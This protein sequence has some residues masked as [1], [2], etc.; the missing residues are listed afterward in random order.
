VALL[1]SGLVGALRVAQDRAQCLALAL[2]ERIAALAEA[3]RCKD[4]FMALLAHELRSP[5]A[6]ISYSLNVLEKR[7]DPPTVRRMR[8]IIARQVAQV[9]RL[10]DELLDTS[11]VSRGKIRLHKERLD[12]VG[13]IRDTLADHGAELR[14]ANLTCMCDLPQRAVWVQADAT[15]LSQ[16]LSNL[17][18][19]AVKF[20]QP[21]GQLTVL[22]APDGALRRAVVIVRDTGIGIEAT[23]LPHLFETYTQG[24]R[25]LSR[26]P[27]GLGLGL[28]LVKA[29]VELHGGKVSASS[30]G[31]G[32]GAEFSFWLPLQHGPTMA[33]LECVAPGPQMALD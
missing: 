31:A 22:L 8:E 23:L 16:V 17:V 28:A 20:T 7:D 32:R 13:L 24:E 21:G 33:D 5:L 9:N 15:R 27:G 26:N 12:L 4:E 29:L 6:P 14:A 2:R 10:V 25:G 19:N 1:L 11:R 3:E 30:A 18:H